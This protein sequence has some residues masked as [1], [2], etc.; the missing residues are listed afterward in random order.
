MFISSIVAIPEH[1]ED[2]Q[3]RLCNG[4]EERLFG[5]FQGRLAADDDDFLTKMPGNLADGI[6][7]MDANGKSW[8]NQSIVRLRHDKNLL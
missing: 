8:Q 7:S 2:L 5:F 4:I 1:A 6:I 3:I